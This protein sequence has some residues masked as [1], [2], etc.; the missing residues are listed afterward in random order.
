MF[1]ALRRGGRDLGFWRRLFKRVDPLAKPCRCGRPAQVRVAPERKFF[2]LTGE[3]FCL[4]CLQRMASQALAARTAGCVLV[5]PDRDAPC[6]V[7][8][9]LEEPP[10]LTYWPTRLAEL[11]P[12]RAFT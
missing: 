3:V 9:E 1:A 4:T 7:P 11:L 12:A 8:Y 10:N 5:Q 6:L 2:F